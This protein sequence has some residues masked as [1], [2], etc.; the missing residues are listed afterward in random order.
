MTANCCRSY[1]LAPQLR[2]WR[3]VASAEEKPL[4]LLALLQQLAGL[5]TIVFTGSVCF[6][7]CASGAPETH[8][9]SVYAAG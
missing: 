2:Q 6:S 8:S 3:V 4:T 5:L 7:T 9:R 1:Q